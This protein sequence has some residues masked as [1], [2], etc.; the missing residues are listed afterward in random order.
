MNTKN[1]QP[2]TRRFIHSATRW[3]CLFA[4]MLILC[5]LAASEALGQK[6]CIEAYKDCSACG[7]DTSLGRNL[8]GISTNKEGKC[9]VM[10]TIIELWKADPSIPNRIE[11]P[12]IEE[13]WRPRGPKVNFREWR[14]PAYKP[15]TCSVLA[16]K[17]L[18]FLNGLRFHPTDRPKI[19]PGRKGSVRLGNRR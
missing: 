1:S 2:Q 12:F 4:A 11:Q 9:V 13:L 10:R 16:D 18:R 5:N 6:S 8:I 17:T 15:Y 7:G 19:P 14:N 3:V